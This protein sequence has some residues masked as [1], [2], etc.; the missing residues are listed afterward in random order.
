MLKTLKKSLALRIA[1]PVILLVLILGVMLDRFVLN[2]VSDFTKAQIQRDLGSLSRRIYNICNINFE[3]LLMAGQA[4][5]IE[6]LTIKKGLTLGQIEDFLVQENLLGI[7][8]DENLKEIILKNSLPSEPGEWLKIG[9]KTDGLNI[10]DVIVKG[11]ISFYE[12]F[13]PWGWQ[14]VIFKNKKEY[15]ALKTKVN[16]VNRNTL[17][18]LI[19]ASIFLIFFIYKTIIKPINTIIYPLRKGKKPNYQGID[20]FEFLSDSITGMMDTIKQNEEKYRSIVET[21]TG[22]VWEVDRKGNYTFISETVKEIL[23]YEPEELLGKSPFLTMPDDEIDRMIPVFKDNAINLKPFDDLINK[24][25]HKQ[26]A[27]VFLETRGVPILAKNGKSL[28]YRGINKDIT[29]ELHA[30]KEHKELEHHR[31]QIQKLEAIGTLAAGLAHDFNNLLSVIMGNISLAKVEIKKDLHVNKFLSQA[32]AAS[33]RAGDLSGKLITF[34]KGGMPIKKMGSIRDL[35]QETTD[36]VLKN[37]KIK[38][39]LRIQEDLPLVEFD[40]TQMTQVI[41][42]IMTNAVESMPDGGSITIEAHSIEAR[43]SANNVESSLPGKEYIKIMIKDQGV[44]LERKYLDKIFDPYFT[45]KGMGAKKG[46]GLGLTTAYSIVT[47]HEGRIIVESESDSGTIVTLYLP[48]YEKEKQLDPVDNIVPV[49]AK[50]GKILLM[51]DEKMIR[52]LAEAMLIK[53]G[54]HPETAIDGTHA[55][56]LYKE[57]HS[58]GS[59]FDLV[60]LDLTV[61]KGMGGLSCIKALRKINPDVKAIVSSGYATDPVMISCKKYGFILTLPKPYNKVEIEMAIN[62]V[63]GNN[64]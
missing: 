42:N 10:Q 19:F 22:F 29:Q 55:V 63:I 5:S 51:D 15:T 4:D 54:Y 1:F 60:I 44:G 23:G 43:D 45:T 31:Y 34:S 24:N 26:G 2:V 64:K 21:T 41:K 3:N 13:S 52:T 28:G 18:I 36:S 7:V 30:E 57:A 47:R 11:W 12:A 38:P 61:K 59:P 20:T 48:A 50:T 27:I 46:S 62:K 17:M 9:K 49:S 8:V 40:E 35:L 56:A 58:C 39:L 37:K 6:A 16:K 14:I 53:L 33:I 25:I 32:E